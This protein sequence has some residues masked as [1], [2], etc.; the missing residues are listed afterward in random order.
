MEKSVICVTCYVIPNAGKR[1][2]QFGT[3]T[4]HTLEWEID[5]RN[6]KIMNLTISILKGYKIGRITTAQS[7]SDMLPKHQTSE[8]SL[9]TSEVVTLVHIIHVCTSGRSQLCDVKTTH[10]STLLVVQMS[11]LFPHWQ[12]TATPSSCYIW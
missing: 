12:S 1:A 8:I 2:L 7:T 6:L 3:I 11:C 9:K 4:K 10:Q 5:E